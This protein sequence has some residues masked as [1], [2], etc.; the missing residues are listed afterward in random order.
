MLCA[1]HPPLLVGP[2]GG[3]LVELACVWAKQ[4][5]FTSVFQLGAAL[6]TEANTRDFRT[7]LLLLLLLLWG[8]LR[9]AF[10]LFNSIV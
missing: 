2:S 8:V 9:R 1:D 7:L 10:L 6:I 5:R 4:A 3:A